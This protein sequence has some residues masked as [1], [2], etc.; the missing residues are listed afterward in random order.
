M[1]PPSADDSE[2]APRERAPRSSPTAEAKRSAGRSAQACSRPQGPP[3]VGVAGERAAP[4]SGSGQQSRPRG[5]AR[6]AG[7]G[8]GVGEARS[9]R[10]LED[11]AL[12]A[13]QHLQARVQPSRACKT[14]VREPTG[15]SNKSPSLTSNR[16]IRRRSTSPATKWPEELARSQA[17]DCSRRRRAGQRHPTREPR[18]FRSP[19]G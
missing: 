2:R 16:G 18:R 9:R 1:R 7:G 19:P 10:R 8:R 3:D 12:L 13:R 14:S 15:L 5:N 11:L 17:E 4:R 6:H